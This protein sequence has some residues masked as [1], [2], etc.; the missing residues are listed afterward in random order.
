MVAL[1]C[2]CVDCWLGECA[3]YLPFVR[4]TLIPK[5]QIAVQSVLVDSEFLK[6]EA[7]IVG[8][9]HSLIVLSLSVLLGMGVSEG[10]SIWIGW[11]VLRGATLHILKHVSSQVSSSMQTLPILLLTV[12]IWAAF[13]LR[14]LKLNGCL[15]DLILSGEGLRLISWFG[16][17]CQL[18]VVRTSHT[19]IVVQ[20]WRNSR[21]ICWL[22]VPIRRF[23]LISVCR[24]TILLSLRRVCHSRRIQRIHHV[25]LRKVLSLSFIGHHEV[26]SLFGLFCCVHSN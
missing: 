13:K 24:I 4:R 15:T 12:S 20:A 17:R 21:W 2:D 23:I 16:R 11:V 6:R 18:W 8:F 25:V 5:V 10:F 3:F 19:R 7:L 22:V 9:G 26:C 14:V 1:T